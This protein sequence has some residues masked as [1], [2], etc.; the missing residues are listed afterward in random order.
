MFPPKAKDFYE[1]VDDVGFMPRAN[2]QMAARAEVEGARSM[3][4]FTPPG[5]TIFA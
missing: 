1:L 3:M 4:S 2:A 5:L